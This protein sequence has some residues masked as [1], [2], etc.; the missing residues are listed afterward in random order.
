MLITCEQT[1]SNPDFFKKSCVNPVGATGKL[2]IPIIHR[3]VQQG[4]EVTAIVRNS[5]KAKEA[6][7]AEVKLIEA[8]LEN[9]QSLNQALKNTET[10]YL[11]LSTHPTSDGFQAEI[12]GLKNLLE[13]ASG[14]PL[15]HIIKISAIGAIHPEFN[16]KGDQLPANKI[17]LESH[18]ILKKSGINYTIL[19]PTWFLNALP[20]FIKVE[21]YFVYG[22]DEYPLYWTNTTDFA[23]HIEQAIDNE[24]A[25]T[26]EFPVQGKKPLTFAQAGEKYRQLIKPELKL[27]Q[28]PVDGEGGKFALLMGYYENFREEMVAQKTWKILGE[29]KTST[30]QFISDAF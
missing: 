2:A 26:Q 4:I 1:Y 3:L 11:N 7:P 24:N 12:D 21:A 14:T 28:V 22:R 20:W 9:V 5:D 29:P 8:D 10:L 25:Y 27:K 18:K 17:R 19:H 13:A 16:I 23:D 15:K 6:L 30:N